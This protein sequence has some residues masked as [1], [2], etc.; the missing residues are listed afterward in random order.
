MV[1]PLGPIHPILTEPIG[2]R[3]AL[4]GETVT[5]VETHT[6]YTRRGVEQLATQHALPEMLNLVEHICGTCGHSHRLA[7]SLALEAF[8][9]TQVPPRAA[10]L[11]T[12]FAEVERALARLWMLQQVARAT[13]M[14]GLLTATVEAREVLFEGCVAATDARL[15]WGIPVPGGAVNVSDPDALTDAVA[16]VMPR[17]TAIERLVGAKSSLVRRATKIGQIEELAVGD[18]SLSG[19]LARGL[20]AA[21]DARLSDA[22]YDAYPDVK[23]E[24]LHD[25]ALAK[26]MTGDTASRLRWAVAEIGM[27]LRLIQTLLDQLPEGQE[28]ASFPTTLPSGEISAAVEGPHGYETVTLHIGDGAG[29]GRTVDS[30]KA[31]WLTALQLHTPSATN[32]GIVPITLNQ[33]RLSDVALVLASLDLCI[34]CADL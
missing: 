19:L 12:I 34:A 15:F 11:R 8:T 22:P 18:L 21:E 6:G 29:S 33:Q 20:G 25:A 3:L 13:E 17:I 30:T 31:G 4:R 16:S 32:I 27:S 14:G 28:R 26:L 5:G 1:F 2:L 9:G 7:V 24:L 10:A 23:D